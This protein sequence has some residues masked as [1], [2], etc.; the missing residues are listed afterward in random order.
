MNIQSNMKVMNEPSCA[1]GLADCAVCE[2]AST[3]GAK[4]GSWVWDKSRKKYNFTKRSQNLF[5]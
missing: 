3:F 5:K 1:C 2:I 4:S